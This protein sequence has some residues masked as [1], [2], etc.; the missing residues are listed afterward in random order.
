MGENPRAVET[1]WTGVDSKAEIG[2]SRLQDSM[3]TKRHINNAR[4]GDDQARS[5]SGNM[6][7]RLGKRENIR[8][9]LNRRRE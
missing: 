4:T 9:T 5:R 6:F 1:Q 7:R 3:R 2:H 8:D